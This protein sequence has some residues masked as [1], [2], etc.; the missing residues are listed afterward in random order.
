MIRA[1]EIKAGSRAEYLER[2]RASGDCEGVSD[3]T[4]MFTGNCV[5]IAF[6]RALDELGPHKK[7]AELAGR[8][9]DV[10]SR[11]GEVLLCARPWGETFVRLVGKAERDLGG[12]RRWSSLS[13]AQVS[14]LFQQMSL[15]SPGEETWVRF[16]LPTFRLWLKCRQTSPLLIRLANRTWLTREEMVEHYWR[17]LAD[18]AWLVV[19]SLET[20]AEEAGIPFGLLRPWDVLVK[21]DLMTDVWVLRKRARDE[22]GVKL[23]Y[24]PSGSQI[25]SALAA[26]DPLLRQSEDD[27]SV[28]YLVYETV[29]SL[30]RRNR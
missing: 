16:P 6:E 21:D 19:L 26:R 25:P 4:L 24:A 15:A 29:Y 20:T 23:P 27:Y 14:Q 3:E 17:V 1:L 7:L 13:L 18:E 5:G 11:A 30:G 28:Q 2:M 9:G 8:R 12:R 22:L 10:V